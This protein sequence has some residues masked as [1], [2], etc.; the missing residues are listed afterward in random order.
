MHVTTMDNV[1]SFFPK[2]R[3]VSL[4]NIFF[5]K[6]GNNNRIDNILAIKQAVCMKNHSWIIAVTGSLFLLLNLYGIAETISMPLKLGWLTTVSVITDLLWA[7]F[8]A[9]L[10]AI[11]FNRRREEEKGMTGK[12]DANSEEDIARLKRHRAWIF[13]FV[14]LLSALGS[15]NVWLLNDYLGG[16][17]S[18]N[19][20][21][22][23]DLILNL[24]LLGYVVLM[25]R[26]KAV[27][28]SLLLVIVIYTLVEAGLYFWRG[29]W[30]T[31]LSLLAFIV[32]FGYGILA[33]VNRTNYRIA[34]L[35]ILPLALIAFM[36]FSELD[37]SGFNKVIQNHLLLEDQ[38]SATL[39]LLQNE[40]GQF[41]QRETPSK[42]DVR[43][44]TDA[45]T[46]FQEKVTEVITSIDTIKAEYEGQI[47][48]LARNLALERLRMYRGLMELQVEQN[49]QLLEMMLYA[50]KIDFSSL[51]EQELSRLNDFEKAID[52]VAER[53][54]K[55]QFELNQFDQQYGD[56]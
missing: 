41:V 5:L 22:I 20:F 37:S 4:T 19:V 29:D 42:D 9:F 34:H 30:F 52:E 40:Y 25:F 23:F 11:F 39:G 10:L 33:K 50:G 24:V 46:K 31:S 26:T 27:P 3:S 45:T 36:G 49:T 18:A 12:P 16:M 35:I 15:V 21:V 53:M 2:T 43:D 1:A 38:Y 7:A 13:S 48:S 6:K 28:R 14:L 56:N 8:G 32:Y 44:V 51:N 17:T 54:T 47:P 55:V